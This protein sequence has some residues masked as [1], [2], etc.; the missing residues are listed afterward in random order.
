MGDKDYVLVETVD[1]F[2]MRYVVALPRGANKDWA[3]DTVVMDEAKEFS[4]QYI[5]EQIISHR[6]ISK[7]ELLSLIE[8]D[9][10]Y[11]AS[12]PEEKKIEVFVTPED[13]DTNSNTA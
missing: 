2:R 6:G 4:Q 1:S 13:E 5:G 11:A 8:E 12:W 9:N 10:D 7:E 3:L